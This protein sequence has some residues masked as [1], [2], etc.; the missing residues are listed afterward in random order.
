MPPW[1]LDCGTDGFNVTYMTHGSLAPF[2]GWNSG[3]LR[4][5]ANFNAP[6]A[7]AGATYDSSKVMELGII[8]NSETGGTVEPATLTIDEV[9]LAR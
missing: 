3:A 5:I 6:C 1:N 8:V 7:A 4:L 9:T 2:F